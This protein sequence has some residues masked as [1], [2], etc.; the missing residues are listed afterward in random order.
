MRLSLVAAEDEDRRALKGLSAYGSVKGATAF[1][2]AAVARAP[3][4]LEDLG[5]AV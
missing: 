1:L 3:G 4:D 5:Y 2:L